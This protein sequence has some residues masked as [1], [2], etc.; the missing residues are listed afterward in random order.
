MNTILNLDVELTSQRL[1]QEKSKY[2]DIYGPYSI[3]AS[4]L[5]EESITT[6]KKMECLS[7]LVAILFQQNQ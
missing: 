2:P 4:K 1:L 6:A 7:L 3:E 5:C